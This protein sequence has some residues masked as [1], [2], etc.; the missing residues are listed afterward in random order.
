MAL[1]HAL[2]IAGLMAASTAAFAETLSAKINFPFRAG[3]KTYPAADYQVRISTNG[4]AP[5]IT[6]TNPA[7]NVSHMLLSL[8]GDTNVEAG[9]AKL[10]FNCAQDNAC[11]LAQVQSPTGTRW[12]MWQPKRTA[13]E[14]E[15]MAVVVVPLHAD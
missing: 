6:V 14:L 3:S 8:P 10:V 5:V 2:A 7:T 4:A 11:S 9:K 12:S 13:A 15:R 1:K